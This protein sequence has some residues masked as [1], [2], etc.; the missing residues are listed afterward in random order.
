[1]K[2]KPFASALGSLMYAHVCTSP[3]ISFIVGVLGR[4]QSN[5]GNDNWIAAKKVMRRVEN[6]EIMGYIDSN[7]GGCLDDKKST[8]GYVFMMAGG[9]CWVI[10]GLPTMWTKAQYSQAC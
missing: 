2:D 7:L 1:M 3:N 4:Y 10:F 8:F 6:L 9:A 5:P